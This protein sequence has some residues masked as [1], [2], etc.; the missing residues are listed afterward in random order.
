MRS[1]ILSGFLLLLAVCAAKDILLHAGTHNLL[2]YSETFCILI[3]FTPS[4]KQ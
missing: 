3:C 4:Q 2:T 1:I